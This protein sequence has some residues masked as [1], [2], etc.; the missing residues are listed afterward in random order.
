MSCV[1]DS[2]L[3]DDCTTP[4]APQ[5]PLLT[6]DSTQFAVV[7]TSDSTL[8]S[9]VQAAQAGTPTGPA[10]PVAAAVASSGGGGSIFASI[11]NFGASVVKTVTP[12]STTTGLQLRVN[13]ST[14]QQQYFNPVTGQFVG[15]PI[16]NTTSG[17]GSIFSGSGTS[18]ILVVVALAVAFFAFGGR[19]RLARA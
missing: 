1:Y 8:L 16:S 18:L 9:Q 6:S 10:S 15:G 17:L 11:L 7:P 5:V 12:T 14:G 19:K 13:P 2:T 4:L 3:A